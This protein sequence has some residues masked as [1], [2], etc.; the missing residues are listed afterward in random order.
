MPPKKDPET[1]LPSRYVPKGLTKEQREQQI[2]SIVEKRD[3]PKLD[4]PTKKSKW[5]MKAIEY[6]SKSP[7]IDEI[8]TELKRLGATDDVKQGLEQILDKG[9]GAYYSSGSRPN[10]TAESWAK[11]RLYAVLFGSSRARKVD[12]HI[13]DKYKIPI[14]TTPQIRGGFLPFLIPAIIGLAK[15]AP[16]I[17]TAIVA[18]KIVGAITG[19]RKIIGK[20][21]VNE[22]INKKDY[23]DTYSKDTYAIIKKMSFNPK[24]VSVM[25]SMA[26][27]SQLYAS[28]YDLYEVVSKPS[29]SS[30]V[31]GFKN[32]VKTLLDTPNVFIGDIKAGNIKDWEIVDEEAYFKD[33]ILYEYDADNSRKKLEQLYDDKIISKEIYELGLKILVPNP[34]IIQLR[35]IIKNLRPNIIRWKPNEI[36]NGSKYVGSQ[37]NILYTLEDAFTSPSL[38]K[39]DVIALIH[40]IFQEFSIIYDFRVRNRRINDYR[41]TPIQSISND[42]QYYSATKNWFKVLKRLFSLTNYR[43]QTF[44]TNK[45]KQV[46]ILEK[47]NDILTSDIGIIYQII[48]DLTSLLFIGE[49]YPISP[50]TSK[51]FDEEID[52]LRDRLSNVYSVNQYLIKEKSI[53]KKLSGLLD[54]SKTDFIQSVKSLIDELQKII[55][56]ETFIQIKSSGLLDLIKKYDE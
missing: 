36:L 46:D 23:P 13:I 33:G 27:R 34:N 50:S 14:L 52:L 47:L 35:E 20:G 29:I 53:L 54:G 17:T 41:M 45:L 44:K 42:I 48:G 38:V 26:I 40:G 19:N 4:F 5:T 7:S 21:Q 43:L 1:G 3:R 32:I 2:Q 10:Q 12:K 56:A 25:G 55:D 6:F 51:R 11:A 28:D 30:I 31:S 8:E 16:V 37:N 24:N 39:L 49:N 9:R 18:P 15:V 22:I